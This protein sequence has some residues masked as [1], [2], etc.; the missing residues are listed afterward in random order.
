MTALAER[1]IADAG[2]RVASEIVRDILRGGIAGVIAGGLVVGVGGRLVMRLAALAIPGSAGTATSNGNAIGAITLE[3]TLGLVLGGLFIG[4]FLGAIWVALAPWI[5]GTGVRRAL[6]TMPLAVAFGTVGLVDG[7]NLDFGVLQHA[8]V[9]VAM[10]LVL[11]AAVGFVVALADD[12]LDRVLPGVENTSPGRIAAYA[13]LVVL[14]ALITVPPVLGFL[15]GDRPRV[16]VGLAF[17]VSGGATLT[18]WWLRWRG[19]TDPPRTLQLVGRAGLVAIL[20]LGTVDL[21]P[22]VSQAL[23]A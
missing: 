4:L 22:E 13:V 21:V 10:L 1:T 23:G 15:F 5:P 17:L 14:G 8:P 6:T 11:M 2:N 9:V 7:E 20:I 18:W 19:Q 16:L 12:W 3:G